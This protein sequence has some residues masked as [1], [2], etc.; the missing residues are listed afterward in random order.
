MRFTIPTLLLLI[1][2]AAY[3]ADDFTNSDN[4]SAAA[5][6]RKAL[7]TFAAETDIDHG[8]TEMNN[9]VEGLGGIYNRMSQLTTTTA[10][11]YDAYA[12]LRGEFTAA[13][14]A[15][16]AG[17]G[18]PAQRYAGVGKATIGKLA[19]AEAV[20]NDKELL[21]DMRKFDDDDAAAVWKYALEL[22]KAGANSI[23]KKWP[24]VVAQTNGTSLD[25]K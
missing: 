14:A 9:I 24:R 10:A 22:S 1:A 3:A 12:K 16:T 15:K 6:A 25:L 8:V 4:V 23:A 17:D 21:L 2:T 5:D 13:I 7:T 20:G 11:D 18:I 19:G